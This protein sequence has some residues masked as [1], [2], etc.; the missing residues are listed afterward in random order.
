MSASGT[1]NGLISYEEI[2]VR[3]G[4]A[5]SSASSTRSVAPAASMTLADSFAIATAWP[6][7]R[8]AAS[9]VRSTPD[10]NPQ[11]PLCTTRTA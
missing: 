10:A 8:A 2:H 4:Y 5:G 11:A 6:A 7:T 3:S 1:S 9:I